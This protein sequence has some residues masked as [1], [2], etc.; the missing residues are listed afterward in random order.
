MLVHVLPRS[1][2]GSFRSY[3]KIQPVLFERKVRKVFFSAANP[4]HV[5]GV[6]VIYFHSSD[7]SVVQ[8]MSNPR[9][10]DFYSTKSIF[11]RLN[12]SLAFQRQPSFTCIAIGTF[13]PVSWVA[14]GKKK[15]YVIVG[16]RNCNRRDSWCSL[17]KKLASELTRTTVGGKAEG[18]SESQEEDQELKNI[19]GWY[20]V[21]LAGDRTFVWSTKILLMYN[22]GEQW[23]ISTEDEYSHTKEQS[24]GITSLATQ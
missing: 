19:Q 14:L 6:V 20:A 2:G 11:K 9:P 21:Y 8:E 12:D 15:V 4:G 5:D 22:N 10:F 13:V 3:M 23:W 1:D 16:G 24:I 7:I 17:L 18:I